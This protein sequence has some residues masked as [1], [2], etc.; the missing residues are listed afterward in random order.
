[1]VSSI[2]YINLV[3]LFCLL[4]MASCSEESKKRTIETPTQKVISK[5]S[6]ELVSTPEFNQEEAF[7]Y[8]K[9]QV[10]FGPR[11]P[12]SS[13]HRKCAIWLESELQSIGLKTNIQEAKVT[14]F[15][16]VELDI[17]NITGQLNP[18][19]EKRILLCAHWDSRPFADIDISDR[20]KAIDG[21]NDGASGVG[22]LLSLA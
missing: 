2:K 11:V 17:F 4:L 16:G 9:K 14:A 6:V 7:E 1:M 15:N 20:N 10:E 5:P 8:V 12:N 22:V 13:A 19:A 21:A 3:G 18:E